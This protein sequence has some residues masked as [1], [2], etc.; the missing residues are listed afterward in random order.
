M[1][2]PAPGRQSA[3]G[4]PASGK[5]NE[6]DTVLRRSGLIDPDLAAPTER[7]VL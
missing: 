5:R 1:N 4:W 7:G 2:A 3:E 6:E